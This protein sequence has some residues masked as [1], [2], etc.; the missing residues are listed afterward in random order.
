MNEECIKTKGLRKPCLQSP[1]YKCDPDWIQ[2]NDLLLSLPTTTFVAPD[3]DAGICG[4]DYIF[5]I[6]GVLRVVS[7]E[8]F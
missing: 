6:T 8:P 7:T 5:T 1:F 3:D 4:L 2:T